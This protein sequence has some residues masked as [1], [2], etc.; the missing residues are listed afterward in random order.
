[1]TYLYSTTLTTLR[2]ED[3][4]VAAVPAMDLI[5]LWAPP[6]GALAPLATTTVAAEEEATASGSAAATTTAAMPSPSRGGAGRRL[7]LGGGECGGLGGE[8]GQHRRTG[9]EEGHD[10]GALHLLRPPHLPLPPPP[11]REW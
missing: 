8:R 10:D 4:S 7:G 11:D 6:R 9:G 2:T 3:A 5:V 1:M